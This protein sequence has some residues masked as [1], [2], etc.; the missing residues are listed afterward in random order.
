ME[1]ERRRDGARQLGQQLKGAHVLPRRRS[2]AQGSQ[3]VALAPT[4]ARCEVPLFPS[5]CFFPGDKNPRLSDFL[6]FLVGTERNGWV[7]ILTPL[8]PEAKHKISLES[9]RRFTISLGFEYQEL[10]K[11]S[12]NDKHEDPSNQQ[13][14]VDRFLPQYDD[15]WKAGP[16]Q[17]KAPDGSVVDADIAQD[18]QLRMTKY[19]VTGGDGETRI[20]DFGGIVPPQ[21]TV[22]LLASHDECCFKAGEVEGR[23]WK[24]KGKQSCVDKTD[25]P[26]LHVAAFSVEWGNGCVCTCPEGP[27]PYPIS[28]S[29]LE[30]WHEAWVDWKNGTGEK[31]D[32]P[33][34]ADVWMYP[35]ESTNFS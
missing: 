23:G 18:I 19:Q 3:V 30:A 28:L 1:E 31:P 5:H 34:T 20:I 21:G 9:A 29:E 17:L 10:R 24:E 35:G 6:A 32:L 7:G 15:I 13:D 22:K 27:A 11:G 12:F 8:L 25:G 26:S 4:K 33:R 2:E 14:R 16:C